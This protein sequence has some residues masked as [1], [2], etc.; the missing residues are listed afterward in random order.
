MSRRLKDYDESYFSNMTPAGLFFRIVGAVVVIA[1]SLSVIGF[2]GGWFNAGKEIV[3]AKNV[4]AQWQFAYD[5]DESLD[6]IAVQHCT[7][8]A[9]EE[10]ETNPD[11]KVQRTDQR[12]AIDNN[13]ERVRAE[14]N[15]RLRDAFRARLVAPSDVPDQAPTLQENVAENCV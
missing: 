14:Y 1:L 12:I 13:Y 3:S 11:F 2:F 4:K 9:A 15:G 5:Y 10:A 7:A 6:G 8:V